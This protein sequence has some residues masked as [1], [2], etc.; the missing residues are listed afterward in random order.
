M[1]FIYEIEDQT[2]KLSKDKAKKVADDIVKR[3]SSLYDARQKQIAETN[4]LRDEIYQ[5]KSFTV[6]KETGYK[7]FNLPELTELAQS[8]KAHLYENIYKTPETMFDC[9]GEDEESQS[10]AGTQKAMLVNS[11]T[12]MKLSQEME[13]VTDSIVDSGEAVLFVGWEK[14]VKRV[15]RKKTV[16]EKIQDNILNGF[17]ALFNNSAM[18]NV[19]LQQLKDS[20]RNFVEYDKLVYDGAVVKCLDNLEFV[21]DPFKSEDFENADMM[22]RSF[23]TYDEIINNKNFDLSTEAKEQLKNIDDELNREEH[24][25]KKDGDKDKGKDGLIELIEYWGNIKIDDKMIRNYLIVVADK[26]HIIRFEPNPYLHKPFVYGNIIEDP[27]TRRGI[28]L[29]RVAK[30]LNDIA[31]EILSK[32]VYCLDLQINPVWLSPKKMLDKDVKVKAG[33]VIEYNSDELAKTPLKPEKLDFSKA[34]TGFEFISF[35]KSL[36][37][38]ATGIFKNMTGAEENRMKTATETQ[39]IVSGQSARQNQITDKIYS[40]IVI[41]MIEKVA[42]TIANEQFGTQKLYQYDKTTDGGTNIEITDET[43]NGNYRYIYAD[44]KAHA[45]KTIR[46][47]D[48]LAMIKEFLQD[49]DINKRVDKVELFKM[50]LE[51]M[52]FDNTGRIIYD[53]KEEIDKQ[54]TDINKAKAVQDYANATFNG[55]GVIGGDQGL[56]A[57]NGQMGVPQGVPQEAISGVNQ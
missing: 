23:K 37:E 4:A 55:G 22:Y 53:D 24:E 30:S 20:K 50:A 38:R 57:D 14:R 34:F 42:D 45:E 51:Q 39:A 13:K 43:R 29:L 18:A 9:Q 40:R 5:R 7:R 36:I 33:K 44:S 15:R 25:I 35:F 26:K 27:D 11:F 54:I 52:D 2:Y 32:Q 31:S 6:D 8:F 19:Q 3:Y 17:Q 28:S 56:V 1:N 48:N 21:F 12:K 41:P 46:F 49:P 10:Y 47:K 16:I